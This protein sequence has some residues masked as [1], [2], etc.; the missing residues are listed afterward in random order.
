MKWPYE[1]NGNHEAFGSITPA[2]FVEA[3]KPCVV[4]QKR[5]D[6]SSD[7]ILWDL[8]RSQYEKQ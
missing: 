6:D 4:H 2:E 8:E 7:G 3:I 1:L 5:C